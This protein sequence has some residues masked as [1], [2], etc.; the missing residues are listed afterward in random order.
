M[1]LSVCVFFLYT[2]VEMPSSDLSTKTSRKG[3]FFSD[4][5][6]IVN[7]MAGCW[8]LRCSWNAWS[9]S[10][11]CGQRTNVSSTYSEPILW[12]SAVVY[13]AM[14][15]YSTICTCLHCICAIIF[16]VSLHEQA[17]NAQE[18][19]TAWRIIQQYDLI[20]HIYCLLYTSPSPRD[21]TLSRMPS[22]A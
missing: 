16:G 17:P 7:W 19:G 22:S 20:E 14:S 5:I 8:E 10:S 4:S 18:S 1:Y 12:I 11:P 2:L 13:I 9:R 6:S 3:S 21:A 15:L